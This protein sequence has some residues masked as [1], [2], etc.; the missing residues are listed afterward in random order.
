MGGPV[1]TEAK[2][3]LGSVGGDRI[4][5]FVAGLGGREIRPSSA[6]GVYRAVLEGKADP[7]GINWVEVRQ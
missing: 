3:V 4:F 2:A 1:G 7:V 6:E 5:G